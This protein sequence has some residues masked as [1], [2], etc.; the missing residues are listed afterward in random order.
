MIRAASLFNF[1]IVVIFLQFQRIN[2]YIIAVGLTELLTLS[3]LLWF[4]SDYLFLNL[5]ITI[6]TSPSLS[7][8]FIWTG[9]WA[10]FSALSSFFGA[11]FLFFAKKF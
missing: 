9:I 7:S 8:S 5:N 3:E 10:N 1:F 6:Y 2:R 4:I 11:A